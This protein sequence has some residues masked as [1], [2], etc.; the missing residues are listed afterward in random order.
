MKRGRAIGS[1]REY[2]LETTR[3]IERLVLE[4]S[5]GE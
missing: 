3:E 4:T 1:L 5:K 2:L